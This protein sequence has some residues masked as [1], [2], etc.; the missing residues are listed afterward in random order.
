MGKRKARKKSLQ[1]DVE[2][3]LRWV[4]EADRVAYGSALAAYESELA[5]L[6]AM[7]RERR[8]GAKAEC[9]RRV[10]ATEAEAKRLYEAALLAAREHRRV[11]IAR[12]EA[13][14]RA[15]RARLQLETADAI[16]GVHEQKR[17]RRWEFK[18]MRRRERSIREREREAARRTTAVERRRESDDELRYAI[19]TEH[20]ELLPVFEIVKRDFQPSKR[21]TRREL[22]YEWAA[23][24]PD[25]VE[26][27]RL[28]ASSQSD[29]ELARL[30]KAHH[31]ARLEEDLAAVPF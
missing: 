21:A 15:E 9:L 24:N 3:W 8:Q 2:R 27:A 16:R 19:E 23:E 7:G 29:R 17:S 10:Q 28:R 11:V 14:C 12:A 5:A 25:Q 20:P 4:P 30:A 31:R 26:A 6:R 22:F 1:A 13:H 18:A